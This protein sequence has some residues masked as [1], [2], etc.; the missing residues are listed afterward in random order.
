MLEV[1]AEILLAVDEF[2]C[3]QKLNGLLGCFGVVRIRMVHRNTIENG[4]SREDE[5]VAECKLGVQPVAEN[6]MSQ[7][8]SEEG[9]EIA[10]LLQAILSNDGGGVN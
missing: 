4:D 5:R 8:K 7:L 6:D 1:E 10:G 9:V 3:S 2:L